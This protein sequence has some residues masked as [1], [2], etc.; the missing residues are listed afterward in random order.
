M[1]ATIARPLRCQPG[2]GACP[3]RLP[4][5]RG[6]RVLHRV[7]CRATAPEPAPFHDRSEG[8]AAAPLSVHVQGDLIVNVNLGSTFG[9]DA[10]EQ[11]MAEAVREAL[12]G[13]LEAAQGRCTQV[14][15]GEGGLCTG[16]HHL[17]LDPCV[18]V[19]NLGREG[20]SGTGR[21]PAGAL[22]QAPWR[23][24]RSGIAVHQC[25]GQG[26]LQRGRRRCYWVGACPPSPLLPA[27]SQP[28]PCFVCSARSRLS[29]QADPC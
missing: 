17:R 24:P 22:C 23:L 25:V 2:G 10:S 14:R 16:A 3:P 18:G 6:P 1:P 27:T 4:T 28:D 13:S 12:P 29:W 5:R 21:G 15:W 20:C 11:Q 19:L 7:C 9:G 26:G 8:P